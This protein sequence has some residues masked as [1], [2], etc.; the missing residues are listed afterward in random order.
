MKSLRTLLACLLLAPALAGAEVLST[1]V[2][3]QAL[4][5]TIYHS[6][7]GL[8]HDSRRLS[9]PGGDSRLVL[10]G[11]SSQIQ[12]ET[13]LLVSDK[14]LAVRQQYYRFDALSGDDL[15][16]R[17]IGREITVARVHPATGEEIRQ[18]ATLLSVRDGQAVYRIGERVEMD[19]ALNPWRIVVEADPDLR[20]QPTVVAEVSTPLGG[21]HALELS[22]LSRGFSWD[23]DYV[24]R[25]NPGEGGMD[26]L[27]WATI[28]NATT[29]AFPG[30]KLQLVAGEV[31]RVDTLGEVELRSQEVPAAA[32]AD[33]DRLFEYQL[34]TLEQPVTLPAR[35]SVHVPLFT[36][37]KA[38]VRRL[39]RATAPLALFGAASG[40]QGLRVQTALRFTNS[41][42]GL[43]R[44]LPSGVVRVYQR[45]ADGTGRFLGEARI[46]PVPEGEEAVIDVGA[47]LDIDARRRQ[48]DYKRLPRDEQEAAWVIEFAN[49][50]PEPITVEVSQPFTGVWRI[51]EENHPHRRDTVDAAR[52]DVQVPANGRT[53]LSYRVRSR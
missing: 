1:P 32:P 39:Y 15:L 3:G 38:P 27:A 16:E 5:L 50:K 36:V 42:A 7:L 46:G 52:W 2:S 28:H 40:V 31:N 48:V 24:V 6:D 44:P 45:E 20:E 19:G 4:E 41:G 23:A 30:A 22:Y 8:V 12:P 29:T 18:Q 13:V 25:L 14:P 49:S 9:L 53:L 51:V 10:I 17:M 47:S 34:Y 26:L 43:G 21:E 37:V 35:Q 33:A 11:V